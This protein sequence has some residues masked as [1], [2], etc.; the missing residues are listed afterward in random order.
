S[1]LTQVVVATTGGSSCRCC[2]RSTRRSSKGCSLQRSSCRPEPRPP[3]SV[4]GAAVDPV[5]DGARRLSRGDVHRLPRAHLR[6]PRLPA[7]VPARLGA[8]RR[9]ERLGASG[10]PL[11]A[12]PGGRR[13]CV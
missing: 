8:R 4:G 5:S 7:F 1:W 11:L 10:I 2:G 9:P 6:L 12:E 3:A 13:G